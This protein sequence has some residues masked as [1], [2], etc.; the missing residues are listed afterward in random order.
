MEKKK[1]FDVGKYISDE[2]ENL[3]IPESL[4][5]EKIKARLEEKNIKK[6]KNYRWMAPI[7]TAACMVILISAGIYTQQ[8]DKKTA[9]NSSASS[10]IEP[11]DKNAENDG[12]K[13]YASTQ[14]LYDKI[15]KLLKENRGYESVSNGTAA[16][17]MAVSD[18]ETAS[19]GSV[20]LEASKEESLNDTTT[21]S[22]EYA[23]TNLQVESVD[24]GDIVKNDGRYLYQ[25]LNDD[26]EQKIQIIDTE[27]GLREIAVIDDFSSISEFYVS[28]DTMV[29]I[30]SLWA[31]DDDED[32]LYSSNGTE[33]CYDIAYYTDNSYSKIY[34]YD[35]S[36]RT[37]PKELKQFTLKGGYK[38]SRI[39]D[40]FLYF[41]SGYIT[42]VPK[43]KEDLEA[44]IPVIDGELLGADSIYIPNECE[45]YNYLT[46]IS[47][48]LSNPSE[49]FDKMAVIS[50][51]SNYYVSNNS[52]YVLDWFE[53]EAEDGVACDKTN[54]IRFSYDKGNIEYA[55]EGV[56]DGTVLDQFAMDEHEGFFRIITTVSPYEVETIIDD[57]LNTFIGYQIKDT[58]PESNNVYVLDDEL[59]IAGKIE[60]LAEDELVR[61]A[62]FMGDT[63]YF[64]TFRQTDPL[65][66]VDFSN[67]YKPEILGELKISGFS[68]YLHFYKDNLLLGIGYE[69]D[70]N[71]GRTDGIKLS[72]FD[73]SNPKDVKEIHKL[74]LREY[75]HSDALYNHHAVL[76][77]GAKNI[78]GFSAE[79]YD[80][81][82][83]RDYSV[84]C[85]DD[86]AGFIEK[87]SIDC[88]PDEC[89]YEARGSYIGDKFYFLKQREGVAA[90]DINSGELLEELKIQ[91]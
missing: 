1:I 15:Y 64:V 17:G 52:I 90:Y 42:D 32:T 85:Y 68:E 53:G 75:D 14:E 23:G 65:F 78:I 39:S 40:G 34:I 59:N 48:D 58:Y 2:M 77:N 4:E 36:D 43:D 71:T 62:R 26:E 60:K 27:G 56:V 82:Y 9:L 47:V 67:P 89:Y 10:V 25:L 11:P 21:A 29:L 54:I 13:D 8:F 69:A 41:I 7:A 3:D 73:I 31:M 84:F 37:T 80:Y 33:A 87:Y 79:S 55:A 24:E 70:E 5:P 6:K 46:M 63:G 30:E 38:T 66:S 44:Y 61:S 91:D 50:Y 81:D 18:I 86:N 45:A 12:N 57:V 74:V 28:G 83:K 22:E 88:T 76:I 20:K 16:F 35:I 51:G 72:M 49:I 19:D